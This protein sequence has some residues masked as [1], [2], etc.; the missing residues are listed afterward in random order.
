MNGN[1]TFIN[2]CD[3]KD[4][5]WDPYTTC[6]YEWSNNYNLNV[7]YDLIKKTINKYEN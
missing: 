1:K 6:Q 3:R 7:M 5:C 4:W 2:F